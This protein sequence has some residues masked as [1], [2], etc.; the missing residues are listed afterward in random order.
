MKKTGRMK[1]LWAS[2]VNMELF[3]PWNFGNS[4]NL[5]AWW[6]Q[7]PYRLYRYGLGHDSVLHRIWTCCESIFRESPYSYHAEQ[8]VIIVEY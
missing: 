4:R 2:L 5:A 6:Y 1:R 7:G 3:L 8:K